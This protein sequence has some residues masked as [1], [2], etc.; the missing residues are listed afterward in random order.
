M[1]KNTSLVTLTL[2]ILAMAL[3]P[4][5]RAQIDQ[6]KLPINGSQG[7]ASPAMPQSAAS[8][9]SVSASSIIPIIPLIIDY[10]FAL[11]YF[12]QPL[13]DNPD[14][15][16]IEAY[17]LSEKPPVYQIAL[18]GKQTKRPVIYCNSEARVKALKRNGQDARLAQINMKTDQGPDS[19]APSY[20]FSFV[21]SQRQSV[22][23]RFVLASAASERGV[24]LTPLGTVPGLKLS[25]RG[26]GT[27][28]GEGTAV[29]IGTKV[30][31]AEPWP[32][33]SAPPYFVA[34]HGFYTERLDSGTI[35]PGNDSWRVVSAP[36][37]LT[38]GALW[39]LTN[40]RKDQRQFRIIT[41]RGDELTIAEV[42]NSP[43]ASTLSL[44]TKAT[45]Q[46]LVLGAINVAFASRN[47]R[48]TFKP[49]LLLMSGAA[50]SESEFTIDE[51][52]HA[53]VSEGTV[54]LTS[55]PSGLRL[56]WQPKS[57]DWAKSRVI[58]STIKIDAT[59]YSI[60]VQ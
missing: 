3:L 58:T 10:Q 29:Q 35:M 59:G 23:W 36:K 27:T 12:M 31:E 8:P 21:D 55:D 54:S 47:F 57:P 22:V 40:D 49:E 26:N 24:G 38:E 28:A 41:K 48:M 6:T 56:R 32:E 44:I 20:E 1:R 4:K 51:G 33:I 39:T 9:V 37:E 7:A 5:C 30:S 43:D 15:S 18:T 25:Y 45:P 52:D 13:N 2:I 60:A 46:G 53:G 16:I 50:S 17:V 19:Q 34:Y 42:N 14:Y 11:K